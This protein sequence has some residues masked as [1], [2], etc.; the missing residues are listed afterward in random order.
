MDKYV[1]K[2][3]YQAFEDR[4]QEFIDAGLP[5]VALVARYRGQP[6]N[7]AQFEYFPCP[8]L[9]VEVRIDWQ[10]DG[11]TYTG[12]ELINFHL[13]T[14]PTWDDSSLATNMDE[15]L[16]YYDLLALVRDVLDNFSHER[17]GTMMRTQDHNIE[18]EVVGYDVLGYKCLYYDQYGKG[19][20]Y[21]EATPEGIELENL[22]L[23]KQ[24]PEQSEDD[25]WVTTI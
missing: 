22:Q 23:E 4:K 1:L 8:A 17:T 18:D 25:P 15:G 11:R 13:V 3:I 12:T 16:K 24:L 20:D 19:P 5:P 7:P 6:Q 14:K 21:G 2:A 10:R 9:F